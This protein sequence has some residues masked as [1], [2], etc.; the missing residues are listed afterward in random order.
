LKN[1]YE[2]RGE[3]TAISLNSKYGEV[4]TLIDTEDLG[5]VDCFPNT[6][7]AHW[8]P[9]TKSFYCDGSLYLE[10]KQIT[11]RM[12][13]YIT[14]CPEDMVPDH[15]NNDTLNNRRSNLRLATNAENK[16]NLN[17]AYQNNQSSGIRGVSWH[18]HSRKWVAHIRTKG[19]RQHL[20][21][22]HTVAEAEKAVLEAR[23]NHM[24][25]SK[26]AIYQN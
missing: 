10:G 8:Y 11:V 22:F 20:G 4:E 7:Y 3:I 18:K 6:W 24:P 16:Q 26:E 19:K 2:I 5:I 12:H 15:I 23:R 25:F 21:Y 14:D 1:S 9:N 17:G 13:R